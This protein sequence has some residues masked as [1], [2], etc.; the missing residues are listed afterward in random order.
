MGDGSVSI[1]R[2]VY[3]SDSEL[4]KVINKVKKITSNRENPVIA[5]TRNF[6]IDM[7]ELLLLKKLAVFFMNEIHLSIS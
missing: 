7:V 2:E 1:I 3:T 6:A 4:E 5:S